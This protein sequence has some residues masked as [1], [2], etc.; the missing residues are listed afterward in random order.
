MDSITIDEVMSKTKSIMK[1]D[2]QPF[3]CRGNPT[4]NMQQINK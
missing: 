1:T 2:E 4:F 3:T